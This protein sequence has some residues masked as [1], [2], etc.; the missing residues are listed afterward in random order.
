M[1]TKRTGRP[2]ERPKVEYFIS[3]PSS[4]MDHGPLSAFLEQHGVD[5]WRRDQMICDVTT[6]IFRYGHAQESELLK[7]HL[8]N[9][10]AAAGKLE[11]VMPKLG[12]KA[13]V[14]FSSAILSALPPAEPTAANER[15]RR[16]SYLAPSLAMI[17]AGAADGLE[18]LRS[19]SGRPRTSK[20][21]FVDELKSSWVRGTGKQPTVSGGTTFE[22]PHSAFSQFVKI[23]TGMLPDPSEFEIGFAD[24][25]RDRWRGGKTIQKI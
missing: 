22:T 5:A 21:K 16:F 11:A 23:A 2:R 12:S 19:K 9:F 18:K 4:G 1:V 7:S 25:M 24:L 17:C 15:V 20:R 13:Y 14:Q 6:A 3:F 8:E 10:V